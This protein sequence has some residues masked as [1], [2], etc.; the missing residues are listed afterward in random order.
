[1]MNL[2]NNAQSLLDDILARL[3]HSTLYQEIDLPLD[4]A[5]YSF[6]FETPGQIDRQQFKNVLT[7]FYQHLSQA[8]LKQTAKLNES[9]AF[10]G[11]A[12]D[13]LGPVRSIGFAAGR[14][15]LE[16][17]FLRIRRRTV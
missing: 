11:L 15:L 17:R 13:R 6:A 7:R 3:D 5:F 14:D 9:Q 2:N 4:L 8:G 10:E 16:S 1:M 12:R